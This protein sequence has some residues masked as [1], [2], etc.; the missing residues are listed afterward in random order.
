MFQKLAQKF[1]SHLLAHHFGIFN[2][3]VKKVFGALAL[4]VYLL[5]VKFCPFLMSNTEDI[6]DLARSIILKNVLAQLVFPFDFLF[7]TNH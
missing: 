6:C 4:Y 3:T 5:Y 7:Y 2:D 1:V